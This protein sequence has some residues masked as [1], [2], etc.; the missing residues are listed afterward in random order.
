MNITQESTGNLTATIKIELSP[1]DYNEKVMKS[2]KELQ[3]KSTL[4]G[5]R[6]G[7]VPF[8][9]IKKMYEKGVL[10]EE[11]NKILSE[12]LNNYIVENKLEILGYPLTNEEKNKDIDFENSDHF[13]FYFD[14]GLT[15]SFELEISDKTEADFYDIKV[16]DK[17]VDSYVE[18]TRKRHGLQIH[19]ETIEEEDM[20]TGEFIQLDEQ[21]VVLENGIQHPGSFLVNFLKDEAIKKEILGKKPGDKLRFNPLK[22]T[23]NVYDT[24][25]M[26]GITK[27][28][29]EKLE[30]DFEFTIGEI[31]RT[32]PVAI[33][34]ELFTKVYP[35]EGI[36]T[37]EQFREK[38]RNEA[39]SYY[40]KESENFFVHNTLEKLIHDTKIDLPDEFVKRW[41][42]ESDEKITAESLEKNYA[43]YADSLRQQ[44]V[45]DK[46]A[47]DNNIKIEHEDVRNHIKGYFSTQYKFDT[48]NEESSKQLDT[49]TDSIMKNKEEVNKIYDELFD[50]QIRELFKEKL[51]LNTKEVTYEEFM[52]Q[53]NEHHKTHH[54][55]HE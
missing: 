32:E 3:H 30:S 34:K 36:E 35:G 51:K 42:V 29:A 12:A 41:L 18:E 13:T 11:V 24:A 28:V 17:I 2:L 21:G 33:D 4:K 5:F 50:K 48:E 10:A 46:I 20:V 44:L 38:L 37:E 27:E 6:P 1:E 23:G 8:G 40:Q 53:V 43:S 49:I 7:K 26:L 54:H 22:A 15:P 52:K 19:P 9:M 45:V 25:H 16:E 47:K 14:I 55:E 39:K 31:T